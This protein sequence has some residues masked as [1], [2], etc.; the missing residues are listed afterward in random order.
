MNKWNYKDAYDE[1][2]KDFFFF[3]PFNSFFFRFIQLFFFFFFFFFGDAEYEVKPNFVFYGLGWV[4]FFP[5]T[6]L[7]SLPMRNVGCV[8]YVCLF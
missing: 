2:R 8:L 5:F 6:S 4:L 3:F 1:M 7:L